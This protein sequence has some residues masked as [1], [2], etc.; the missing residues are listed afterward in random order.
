MS[1]ESPDPDA[2]IERIKSTLEKANLDLFENLRLFAERI[3]LYRIVRA[4]DKSLELRFFARLLTEVG[5]MSENPAVLLN[6]IS[7]IETLAKE[8]L[9]QSEA[10]ELFSTMVHSTESLHPR[11]LYYLIEK[12]RT[13]PAAE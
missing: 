4:E 13:E 1:L 10:T 2:G 6:E 12:L 9:S 11:E 8:E 7:E 5:T 3:M